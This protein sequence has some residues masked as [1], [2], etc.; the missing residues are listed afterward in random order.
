MTVHEQRKNINSRNFSAV[1]NDIKVDKDHIAGYAIVG[2][3]GPNARSIVHPLQ[4]LNPTTVFKLRALGLEV[5]GKTGVTCTRTTSERALAIVG[6]ITRN[7]P[8]VSSYCDVIHDRL[9]TNPHDQAVHLIFGVS[10]RVGTRA[11]DEVLIEA[12]IVE[13]IMSP[14]EVKVLNLPGHV[15]RGYIYGRQLITDMRLQ[16]D[17]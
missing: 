8:R 14:L 16:I 2:V 6:A 7:K 4:V 3:V 15:G 1:F 10:Q 9:S 5:F 11:V 17:V 13:R 12:E